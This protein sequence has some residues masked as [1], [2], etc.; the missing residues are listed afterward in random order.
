MTEPRRTILSHAA[1][2]KQYTFSKDYR[3]ILFEEDE[4]MVC[5]TFGS[6]PDCSPQNPFPSP[7]SIA[8]GMKES[9]L[10]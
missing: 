3:Q 5:G 1:P 10:N 4:S 7:T 2:L 8:V 9:H 6:V